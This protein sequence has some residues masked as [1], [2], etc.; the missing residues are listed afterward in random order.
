MRIGNDLLPKIPVE[1]LIIIHVK[2]SCIIGQL[3]EYIEYKV[4]IFILLQDLEITALVNNSYL[5]C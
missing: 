5:T 3:T 4:S 1:T 2:L